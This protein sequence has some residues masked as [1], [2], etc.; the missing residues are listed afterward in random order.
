MFVQCFLKPS[1]SA[2]WNGKLDNATGISSIVTVSDKA[3]VFLVLENNWN[4][5]MDTNK[6]SKNEHA[7]SKQGSRK[8]IVSDVLPV[9][10]NVNGGVHRS[11]GNR[12]VNR[13]WTEAGIL[14]FNELCKITK[15]DREAH[16]NADK[17]LLEKMRSTMATKQSSGKHATLN[18]PTTKAHV[19][20]QIDDDSSESSDDGSSDKEDS[21]NWS[22]QSK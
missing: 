9:F 3:F 21:D 19:D 1:Y 14:Q 5:W 8:P 6:K 7:L 22:E 4:R 15:E 18:E 17:E 12:E 13:G 2:K 10:T 20:C 11:G 16:G